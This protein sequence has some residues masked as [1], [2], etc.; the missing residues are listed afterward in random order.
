VDFSLRSA[1][2]NQNTVSSTEDGVALCVTIA[3]VLITSISY[4]TSTPIHT[5]WVTVGCIV[6]I[7][8]QSPRPTQPSS[9]CGTENEY[10]PKCG[11]ALRRG[12]KSRMARSIRG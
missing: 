1:F 12:N 11:D 9:L 8:N 10:R 2:C 3:T 5:G 4:S 6:L 7:C